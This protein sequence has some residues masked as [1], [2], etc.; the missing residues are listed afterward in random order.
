MGDLKKEFDKEFFKFIKTCDKD[1][2]TTAVHFA[3]WMAE[4]ISDLP[5]TNN[6]YQIRSLAK[7]LE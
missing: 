3:K 6:F 2:F 7:D 5:D 1:H 4:Y